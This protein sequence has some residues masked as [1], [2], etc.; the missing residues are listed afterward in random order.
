MDLVGRDHDG[1][2]WSVA[3]RLPSKEERVLHLK[4]SLDSSCMRVEAPLLRDVGGNLVKNA[5][6][7]KAKKKKNR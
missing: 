6:N 7:A 3:L 4:E 5:L 1:K 2:N